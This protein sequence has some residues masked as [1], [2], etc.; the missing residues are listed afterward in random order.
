MLCIWVK[1]WACPYVATKAVGKN[2]TGGPKFLSS[3]FS[4]ADETR[5][6]CLHRCA[7]GG[8]YDSCL[9]PLASVTRQGPCALLF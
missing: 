4:A 3:L 5:L 2:W 8:S 6:G 7:S 1:R 9:K